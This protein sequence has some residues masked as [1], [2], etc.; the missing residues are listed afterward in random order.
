MADDVITPN[1]LGTISAVEIVDK[2]RVYFI[3]E[4][5]QGSSPATR[6]LSA[7]EVEDLLSIPPPTPSDPGVSNEITSTAHGLLA[8]DIG[9]PVGFRANGK[10]Y[11][12]ND[13][14]TTEY[15]V[16]IL[17]DVPDVNTIKL[18]YP[19][20]LL[21]VASSLFPASMPVVGGETNSR[22]MYWDLTSQ[23]YVH[24]CPSDSVYALECVAWISEAA[25]VAKII[26]LLPGRA[27]P[28][29]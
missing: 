21:S 11:I 18:A 29:L 7:E 28:N 3:I 12:W 22:V 13:A 15:P 16:A 2:T 17:C 9:K 1:M 26:S 6:R 23:T 4:N 27:V 8:A 5:M 10:P 14:G 24:D 20:S 25:S 19:G